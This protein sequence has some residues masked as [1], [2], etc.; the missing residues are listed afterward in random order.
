[1]RLKAKRDANHQTIVDC[2]RSLGMSVLDLGA[3]GHG[4]PDLVVGLAN[5]NVL[6]EIKDGDKPPSA[7]QLTPDQQEF[8]ATW[9]GELWVVKD[10]QDCLRLRDQMYA[11]S[12]ALKKDA[13]IRN[14]QG[15]LRS[16]LKG[17]SW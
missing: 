14:E 8:F 12:L 2:C 15:I 4:A 9:H 7:R 5:I 17:R 6:V 1:M 13:N 3:V 10:T 16:H 11:K